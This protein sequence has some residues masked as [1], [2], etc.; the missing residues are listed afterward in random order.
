MFNRCLARFIKS[1]LGNFGKTSVSQMKQ[2]KTRASNQSAS[3][4]GK[5]QA[6]SSNPSIEVPDEIKKA[7]IS[8]KG[9]DAEMVSMFKKMKAQGAGD[10]AKE[11]VDKIFSSEI[12]MPSFLD[13]EK[14]KPPKKVDK[15]DYKSLFPGKQKLEKP[16]KEYD[17]P[18][19]AQ[20]KV[21]KEMKHYVSSI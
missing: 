2:E 13:K 6:T 1:N 10:Y 7:G 4:K 12:T 14:E 3:T 21:Q 18:K 16:Y 9:F 20:E 8:S 17:F 19:E 15:V 11:Q 5:R